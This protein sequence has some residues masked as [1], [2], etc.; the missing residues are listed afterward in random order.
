MP[1]RPVCDCCAIVTSALTATPVVHRRT[2]EETT[3]R[4]CATCLISAGRAW[5]LAWQ[6]SSEVGRIEG[7]RR[8]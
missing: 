8:W 3:L 7:E 4:L 6:P 1:E 5:R 2:A